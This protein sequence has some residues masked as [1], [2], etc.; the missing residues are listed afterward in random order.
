MKPVKSDKK[1]VY[2]VAGIGLVAALVIVEILD[3][4]TRFVFGA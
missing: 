3:T 2:A 1:K 4:V